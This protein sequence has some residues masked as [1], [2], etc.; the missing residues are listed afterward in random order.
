[1]DEAA[2][3]SRFFFC[4]ENSAKNNGKVFNFHAG[5]YLPVCHIINF[6]KFT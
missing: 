5:F 3:R 6:I 1:M 4:R 2:K